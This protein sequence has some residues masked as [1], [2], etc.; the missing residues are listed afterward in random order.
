MAS[1]A[2]CT[3]GA[4]LDS[5]D[6]ITVTVT[7]RDPA[8]GNVIFENATGQPFENRTLT[9]RLGVDESPLG[10]AFMETLA[11]LREG[12]RL[13]RQLNLGP[14]AGDVAGPRIH[15]PHGI[16]KT[17]HRLMFEAKYDVEAEPG[18]IFNA[19]PYYKARVDSIDG[20]YVTY[21]LVPEDGQRDA[22][23]QV[24][25]IMITYVD[26]DNMTQ[27]LE[28]V[29]NATFVVAPS[30]PAP[31]GLEPGSY[32]VLGSNETHLLFGRHPSLLVDWV[33][34]DVLFEVRVTKIVTE[35]ERKA[36]DGHYNPED[37]RSERPPGP[38]PRPTS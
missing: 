17:E 15:G 12:D 26:G 8:T 11:K 21:R 9:L 23:D 14:F 35:E 19:P 18:L 32:L 6:D 13:Q 28:P 34:R 16:V 10:P 24:G 2:G 1:L 37:P 31:L 27:V 29:V 7:L 3:D 33:G 38:R 20:D 36:I 4:R 25:C 5:A 22:V 30:A